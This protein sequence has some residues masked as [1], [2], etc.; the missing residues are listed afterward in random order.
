M[1]NCKAF[2]ELISQFNLIV[3]YEANKPTFKVEDDEGY[4]EYK[5]R[6]D[7]I[8]KGK[9]NRLITQ[10]KY[11]LNEGKIITGKFITY[12]FLGIDDD[13]I[14]GNISKDILNKTI[15]ILKEII[16]K[17]NAEIQYLEILPINPDAYIAA[18]CIRKR[19][20]D[21]YIN[22]Y[23]IAMLGA[24]FHGKTTCVSYLTYGSKDNGNGSGRMAIFKHSHEQN[25][26]I[27][28]SIKHDIFG[29]RKNSIY[30]YKLSP[31]VTWDK[32]VEDS[33][34]IISIFDLPGLL[35]YLRT[36]IFGI[37]T[38]KTDLNIIVISIQ[39]YFNNYV[40]DE[41]LWLI[42]MFVYLDFPFFILFTKLDLFSKDCINDVF[43]KFNV[44]L[45]NI[46]KNYNKKLTPI[47]NFKNNSD[48]ILYEMVSNVTGENYDKL[49]CFF[50]KISQI[51]SNNKNNNN[52]NNNNNINNNKEVDF[53]IYD[54][55]NIREI[56]YI[57]SGIA[58]TNSIS[59]NDKLFIGPITGVFHPLTI[60]SIHK[61]RMDSHII[62][63]G[64]SGSIEIILESDNLK[65]DKHMNIL[66]EKLIHKLRD[67]I[68]IK[69]N[70]LNNLKI[71]YQYILYVDNLIEPVTLDSVD[72]NNI[73]TFEFVKKHKLYIRNNS[74]CVIKT[75]NYFLSV[76]GTSM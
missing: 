10:M 67:K 7:N 43:D 54:V 41:T 47:D 15:D 26:G 68:Y 8:D 35:K 49:I 21:Q 9:L 56:G 36:T 25:T 58:I 59:V 57:V 2:Q 27:T 65:I 17:S 1:F 39:N 73:A 76:F 60:K 51:K 34:K 71:N 70:S 6:L 13:G 46:L 38:L 55:I 4:V 23:R 69:S 72:D 30:N 64:E 75:N 40:P 61:K 3:K 45:S 11:R 62:Y 44:H 14:V 18:L 24:S 5:L 12:Y 16:I 74:K 53:M 33:D 20:N 42:K 66:N 37:L 22:E 48:E 19:F 29:F 31:L 32:I 28:S 50:D 52:N 63:P